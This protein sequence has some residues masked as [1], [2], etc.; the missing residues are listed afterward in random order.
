MEQ[1]G[2]FFAVGPPVAFTEE[3]LSDIPKRNTEVL[4]RGILAGI[5]IIGFNQEMA[6]RREILHRRIQEEFRKLIAERAVLSG[7]PEGGACPECLD[8]VFRPEFPEIVDPI[9]IE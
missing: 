2:D 5:A 1:F 7:H 9:A 6:K 8:A 4:E 3:L